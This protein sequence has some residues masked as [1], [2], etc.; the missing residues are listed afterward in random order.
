M[1]AAMVRGAEMEIL[2]PRQQI[3]ERGHPLI[4]AVLRHFYESTP[5]FLSIEQV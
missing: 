1:V 2:N 3:K 4:C 5:C